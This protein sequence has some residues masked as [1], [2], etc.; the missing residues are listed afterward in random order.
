MQVTDQYDVRIAAGSDLADVACQPKMLGRIERCHLQGD[1]RIEALID[2]VP[3]DAIHMAVVHQG[4]GV[5]IVG[6]QDE[7]PRI[8]PH[9]R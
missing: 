1:H 9:A 6:H 8:Q 3:H 2:R 7:V 5:R 4:A